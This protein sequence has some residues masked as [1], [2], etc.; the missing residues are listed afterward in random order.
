MSEAEASSEGANPSAVAIKANIAARLNV[1]FHQNSVPAIAEIELVNDTDVDLNGVAISISAEPSFL[2]P[3]TFRVDYIRVGGTQRL[4]PVPNDFN[5]KFL[6]GLAEAVRGE[7]T[8]V[9]RV[10]EAEVAI[11]TTPCQL[12]SPSEWT[13]LSTAP[14]LIAAFVRPNDASVDVVLRNAA[15]KLRKAGRNPAL[16]GYQSRKRRALGN[17]RRQFG[18]RFVMSGSSMHYRP[19]ASSATVKKSVCRQRY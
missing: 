18:R 14:E 16:D 2:Q 9:A 1:A 8:V 12:L 13:G 3:K 4:N 19:R 11:L 10:G 7:F 15:E 17:S 6:L 5:V